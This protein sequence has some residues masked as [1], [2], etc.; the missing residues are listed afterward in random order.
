[1]EIT[2]KGIKHGFI[3]GL[4]KGQSSIPPNTLLNA[5]VSLELPQIL[6]NSI[7]VNISDRSDN[8]DSPYSHIMLGTAA[9]ENSN[10]QIEYYA[11]RSVI[12]ERVNQNP[13]LSE[14]KI[15][16]KLHAINAKK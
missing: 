12:E 3:K 7:E 8:I 13:I 10:G 6:S 5:R 16:G 14:A 9:L 15:V 11:V 1:M 4:R 2:G